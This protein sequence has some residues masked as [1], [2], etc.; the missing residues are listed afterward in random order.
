[1]IGALA[2]TYY[3]EKE[4]ID[5]AKMYVVSIMP[6]TAK[7]FEIVRSKEMSSSG[8]QDVDVSITTREFARMIKQSGIDFV[9]VLDE[10]PDLFLAPTRARPDLRRHWRRNGSGSAHGLLL[11]HRSGRSARGIQATR[12]LTGVKEAEI[13]VAGVTVRIAV[14]HGLRNVEHVME[15]VRAAKASGEEMPY[16]FIEVM[17]C[18]GGCVG[19]GGQPYGVTNELRVKRAA[20]L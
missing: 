13:V 12:G 4:G 18:P 7:K 15:K 6:C 16:H 8:Y 20:G 19:G 11:R 9:T 3:A 17:A 5:P 1:M 14:V 10:Q 2:K